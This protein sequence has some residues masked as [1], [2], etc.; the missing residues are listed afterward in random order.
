VQ[1]AI[2]A[3]DGVIVERRAFEPADLD[4]KLFA[5][6]ATNDADLNH[7][8][9]ELGRARGMMVNCVDD[10]DWCD[11][12]YPS[13]LRRGDL[14]ISV[15][16]GGSSPA[17]A[18]LLREGLET[19]FSADFGQ[20]LDLARRMRREAR[21]R[22]G[23]PGARRTAN[24]T[25]ARMIARDTAGA[26]PLPLLRERMEGVVARVEGPAPVAVRLDPAL[27]ERV[28]SAVSPAMGERVGA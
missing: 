26:T 2:E 3:F 18:R 14:A 4:G 13:I 12:L 27:R 9:Y 1:K 25:I 16:T 23:C 22:V 21:R 5:I 8:I 24:E 28:G 19:R 10:P 6:A 15:S 11:F 17:L 7:R 20:R